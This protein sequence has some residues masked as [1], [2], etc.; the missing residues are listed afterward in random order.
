MNSKIYLIKLN[1]HKYI[2]MSEVNK[3]NV[4]EDDEL[5][6]TQ[7]EQLR[8]ATRKKIKNELAFVNDL[9]INWTSIL[10]GLIKGLGECVKYP[11]NNDTERICFS[12]DFKY[13]PNIYQ[14]QYQVIL[15]K[16][17][18]LKKNNDLDKQKGGSIQ[19]AD[20][21]DLAYKLFEIQVKIFRII[22]VILERIV[23]IYIQ[24]LPTIMFG[25]EN[26]DATWEQ[27]MPNLAL[28][29]EKARVQLANMAANPDI[30]KAIQELAQEWAILSVQVIDDVRPSLDLIIDKLWMNGV[31]LVDRSI[32][33]S[34][35]VATSAGKAIV[36]AVPIYGDIVL[37]IWLVVD[38]ISEAI[39][40]ATPPAVAAAGV[41][42]S[43]LS[44]AYNVKN[45]VEQKQQKMADGLRNIQNLTRTSLGEEPIPITTNNTTSSNKSGPNKSGRDPEINK[46]YQQKVKLIQDTADTAI[47]TIQDLTNQILQQVK[48]QKDVLRN[49]IVNSNEPLPVTIVKEQ[50]QQGGKALSTRKLY[51]KI[52]KVHKRL[53]KTINNFSK[54]KI[55]RKTRRRK[56]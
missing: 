13:D 44:T 52:N 22:K 4:N 25:I 6:R 23:D 5:I 8:P 37:F 12:P 20:I 31:E 50:E 46:E 41:T 47:K 43:A 17:E 48:Q 15:D 3:N 26:S 32:Q 39:Q 51:S 35:K 28:Q 54:K 2:V 16:E 56:H 55:K 33:G 11:G 27:A 34:V 49:K 1:P 38:S 30:Q 10:E 42:T 21:D 40:T 24:L 7:L 36:G 14:S 53:N 9:M 29:L 18:K 45:Q 19:A